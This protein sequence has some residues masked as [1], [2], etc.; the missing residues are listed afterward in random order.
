MATGGLQWWGPQFTFRNEFAGKVVR[1]LGGRRQYRVDPHAIPHAPS[2]NDAGVHINFMSGD[3]EDRV[4]EAYR[5]NWHRLIAVKSKYDPRNLLRLN[6]NIPP[7]R[8]VHKSLASKA[9]S[10]RKP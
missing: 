7:R 2:G 8:T 4:P 3:E 5:E 9:V 10:G 1:F 6:Q